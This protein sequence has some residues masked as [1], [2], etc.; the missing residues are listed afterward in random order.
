[1]KKKVLL[2]LAIVA[3]LVI[4]AAGLVNSFL[5]ID[6]G[7]GPQASLALGL[8][9]FICASIISVFLVRFYKKLSRRNRSYEFPSETPFYLYLIQKKR[10]AKNYSRV[11]SGRRLYSRSLSI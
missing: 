11:F 4:C 1:M 2:I 3:C 7:A 8:G 10:E 9:P 6:K 5:L